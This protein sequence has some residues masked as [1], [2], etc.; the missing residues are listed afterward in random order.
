M[1]DEL[2]AIR[3]TAAGHRTVA[4]AGVVRLQG[5]LN[6]P[7]LSSIVHCLSVPMTP[8]YWWRAISTAFLVRPNPPTLAR[9]AQFEHHN[10]LVVTGHTRTRAISRHDVCT[11]VYVRWGD[12]WTEMVPLPWSV[13]GKAVEL[14][15][16]D[17]FLRN[18]EQPQC[19]ALVFKQQCVIPSAVEMGW[20][21]LRQAHVVDQV[22]V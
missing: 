21:T 15:H 19:S 3:R 22:P 16:Q 18:L 13:Y 11:A 14:L 8:R 17:Y 9:L 1:F 2:E 6:P 7:Q 20:H 10:L 4:L 5:Y 12:K